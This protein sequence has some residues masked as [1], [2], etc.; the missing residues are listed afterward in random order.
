MTAEIPAPKRPPPLAS[1]EALGAFSLFGLFL[2]GLILRLLWVLQVRGSPY[3]D[4]P[5]L[6][7]ATFLQQARAVAEGGVDALG[8]FWRPPLYPVLLGW[9]FRAV[10]THGPVI[11]LVLQAALSALT[12]FP[13]HALARR[14]L[15]RPVAL[16]GCAL[17]SVFWVAIFFCGQF[18]IATLFTTLLVVS[19]WTACLA[20]ER[21]GWRIPVAGAMAGLA[22][23]AR[24]TFLPAAA[25]L[26]LWLALRPP[27]GRAFRRAGRALL[28]LAALAAT[29]SPATLHN[30]RHS[31]EFVPVTAIGGYNFFVGNSAGS[32]GR[33]VWSAE[34]SL[35]AMNVPDASPTANQTL[36]LRAAWRDIRSAPGRWAALMLRK[37]GA[38]LHAHEV[39]SNVDLYAMISS[40][41]GFLP[42]LGALSSGILIPLALVGIAAAPGWRR[43]APALIGLGATAA[44]I[45]LF[46]VNARYRVALMPLGCLYAAAGGAALLRAVRRP[47]NSRTALYAAL[48][49]LG[50][51][52]SN[53]P[54]GG[55]RDERDTIDV[56]LMQAQ[57]FLDAGRPDAAEPLIRLVL[58]SAPRHPGA[59]H[60]AD[61]LP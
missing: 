47:W 5:I 56:N 44:A 28:Y 31:G 16:A 3:F 9:L 2:I 26:A 36:Y 53:G 19:L 34:Q 12:V 30:A 45:V 18:L 40:V 52:A 21:G 37:V 20:A 54:W 15:P 61:R 11:A 49:V 43:C 27:R 50:L 22:A 33:T 51:A 7:Q 25:C 23:L 29:V 60:L 17:W 59:L 39:S 24:P 41:G 13:L 42:V 57:A 35:R 38:L 58:T 10:G 46:F 32:D 55:I 6:D 1:G 8:T 48:L 14:W 4:A